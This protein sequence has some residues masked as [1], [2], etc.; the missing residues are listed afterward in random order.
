MATATL[1]ATLNT[2]TPELRPAPMDRILVIA[3]DG[4]L[5]STEEKQLLFA[6]RTSD[7]SAELIPLE[8]VSNW[9]VITPCIKIAIPHKFKR[10]AMELIRARLC[11][12]VHGHR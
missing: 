8:R 7:H 1:A 11:N 6:N 2:P 5:E 4:V 10:V 9:G 3:D 12:R